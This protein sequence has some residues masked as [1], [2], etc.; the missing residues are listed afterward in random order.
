MSTNYDQMTDAELSETF[1]V[2]VAGW[3]KGV[4]FGWKDSD[5]TTVWDYDLDDY[6]SPHFATS[7]DAVLP[8]LEKSSELFEMY[9]DG[10]LWNF[11][12]EDSKGR[13]RYGFAKAPTFPRAVCIAMLRAKEGAP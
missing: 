9:H 4:H 7:A 6:G 5:G 11:S 13:M 10:T 12:N 3:R 1:A 8:R 2:K